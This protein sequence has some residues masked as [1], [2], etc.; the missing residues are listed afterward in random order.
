MPASSRS[1]TLSLL[2]V[3]F[4][5]RA[6]QAQVQLTIEDCIRK[7]LA[8]PSQ[9]SL[10]RLDREI[11][12]R[13]RMQSRAGFLPQGSFNLGHTYNSPNRLDRSTFSYVAL[14]GV[15]EFVALASIFQEIDTSGR[16]RAGYERARA[17]QD[18]AAASLGIAGRDLKRGVAAAY[19]RV[20]LARHLASAIGSSL[21]ES[22][23]FERR[24]RLL[25]DAGESARADLVKASAQA[26]FLRQSVGT[27]DLAASL[28]NQDLASFWTR[29]VTEPLQLV[30]V[31]EAALP[32]PVPPPSSAV[33]PFLRR[34][35]FRLFDAELRGF[36]AESRVA[37]SAMLPKLTWTF[38]YG[39]DS[40]RFSWAD[41]GYAAFANLNVP[42]FDWFH[43]RNASRQFQARAAKVGDSRAIAERVFS[44]EYQAALAKVRL[45]HEQVA[46]GRRQVSLSE[47]DLKLSRLRYEGGE[48]LALDVVTAQNQLAQA[49]TNYFSSIANYLTARL[50]LEVASGQ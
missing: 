29:D 36:R 10:A 7:A 47:E 33:T 45:F 46:Q 9:V 30:D 34:F 17:G 14:N 12:D 21:A 28:A 4:V 16:L 35:E 31:F 11:S 8:V 2:A 13:D 43:A 40:N 23:A 26:A 49:R 32:E 25:A 42:V 41:R 50:D 24:V 38:Q 48:G 19:Y 3:S 18:A 27:A 37:K 44:A 6:Q 15:R 39:F 20:L 5:A 22:E 1:W